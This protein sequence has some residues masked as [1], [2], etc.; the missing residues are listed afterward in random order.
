MSDDS[1]TL[2]DTDMLVRNRN[3]IAKNYVQVSVLQQ[4]LEQELL[5][6]LS[7]LQIEMRTILILGAGSQHIVSEL[8]LRY[9]QA[10]INVCDVAAEMMALSVN[11][12][13][14]VLALTDTTFD[15]IAQEAG[16]F[17]LVFSNLYMP[18][19]GNIGQLVHEVFRVLK[20]NGCF[21][22][23]TLGPYSFIEL[24]RAWQAI[25][26]DNPYHVIEFADMHD[27]GDA[28]VAAG[29]SEP[30]MDCEPFTLTYSSTRSMFDDL[31]DNGIRNYFRERTPGL[32]GK[33]RW[34]A[35]LN[36]LHAV[37]DQEQLTPTPGSRLPVTVEA[38]FGQ[39]WRADAGRN[40]P[41]EDGTV[42]IPLSDLKK[43]N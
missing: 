34:Q 35:F 42:R 4:R 17:D 3:A 18:L 24:R 14:T 30:V 13:N 32:T 38:V 2:F 40:R 33:D 25:E 11:R 43:A 39:A 26:P 15:H 1:T 9:P 28:L 8:A 20:P 23:A 7:I 6:R 16:T 12:T 21:H 10:T 5:E 41:G 37:R 36:G 22:F 19:Y 31:R 29:F 27:V